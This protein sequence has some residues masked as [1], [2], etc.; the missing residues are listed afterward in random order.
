MDSFTESLKIGKLTTSKCSSCKK[1]I[2]PPS[3]ICPNCHSD[4]IEWIIINPNG[5]LLE[6]SETL[7]DNNPKIFGMVKLNENICLLGRII[8]HHNNEL[9]KGINVKLIKCG[10][11]N[12]NV[13]YEFQPK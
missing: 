3:N 12:N 8:C 2:W 11:E 13:Y 10:I 9:K 1:L 4:D 5:K 7:I 6:F